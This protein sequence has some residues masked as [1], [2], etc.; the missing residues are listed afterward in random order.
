[1]TF[2]LLLVASQLLLPCRLLWSVQTHG[3]RTASAEPPT[4]QGRRIAEVMSYRG[5]PWLERESRVL[6][7]DPDALMAALAVAP[8]ATVA[9]LGCGSGYYARRL[10]AAVGERGRVYCVDIQPEMLEIARRLAV[11]VGITNLELVLGAPD[12]PRLPAGA[13]DLILLVDV[14]HELAEPA[15]MLARM[16]SALRPD[17][18]IALVEFRLE[19]E[20]A[21]HIKL[22]HRMSK[23]QVLREW[24][25]AGFE[26]AEQLESLPT[27]HLFLF[28]RAEPEGQTPSPHHEAQDPPP[29]QQVQHQEHGQHGEHEQHGHGQQGYHHDF[30]DAERYARE[31]DSA[32]RRAWQKPEEVIALM[33]IAPGMTVADLGAGTGFFLPYL[34]RAVGEGGR[35][36]GLDIEPG[37]V[38]YMKRRVEREGLAQVEPRQVAADDPGL[39]PGTLDRILVV[40]TW[41]HIDERARYTDRLRQALRPGGK[42]VIVDFER[43]SPHGPPPQHRLT[44]EEVLAELVAGGLVAS[45]VEEELP[46]QYVVVGTAPSP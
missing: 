44:A 24:L 30:A 22:E 6:E 14:Y 13:L 29:G 43:A 37:M 46:Y 38:D 36:L 19:G 20:S 33:A 12:D 15:A 9:D 32:E 40:N 10:A 21:A 35:V 31:F 11:E 25:P 26:L 28:R 41:H 2:S 27:Q 34:A 7:E 17:G 1:V 39:P 3:A 8:G 42:L 4:Y 5:A 16:R 23:E 45:Q 18:R